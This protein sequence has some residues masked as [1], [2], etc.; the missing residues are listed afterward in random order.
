[1]NNE[2]FSQLGFLKKPLTLVI[3]ILS[4]VLSKSFSEESLAIGSGLPS[5]SFF[6]KHLLSSE[7]VKNILLALI[8][9]IILKDR[10][11]KNPRILN[12]VPTPT[13]ELTLSNLSFICRIVSFSVLFDAKT[14]ARIE[15]P[16]I[17]VHE[18]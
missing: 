2:I 18:I 8:S 14:K 6:N 11:K 9:L 13:K 17:S 4:L 1:M 7:L 10:I 16:I 3:V 15:P 5:C 12:Q